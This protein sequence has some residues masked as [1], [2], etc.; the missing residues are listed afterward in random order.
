MNPIERKA[1]RN[2]Y[3]DIS[4]SLYECKSFKEFFKLFPLITKFVN[5]Y[6]N[7]FL[8]ECLIEDVRVI[9]LKFTK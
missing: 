5:K 8:T 3:M 6:T 4:I 2:E 9:E 7:E 1:M